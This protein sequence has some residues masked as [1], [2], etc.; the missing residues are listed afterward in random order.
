MSLASFCNHCT[1]RSAALPKDRAGGSGTTF[2]AEWRKAIQVGRAGQ[3]KE[4]LAPV[5]LADGAGGWVTFIRPHSACK[6]QVAAGRWLCCCWR[7]PSPLLSANSCLLPQ[8]VDSS[9]KKHLRESIAGGFDEER[10]GTRI[11]F[12]NLRRQGRVGEVRGPRKPKGSFAHACLLHLASA[13]VLSHAVARCG[14]QW[15]LS[16]VPAPAGSWRRS[17]RG[18]TAMP[19]L[20]PW[21]C[22]RSAHSPV[23]LAGMWVVSGEPWLPH[24]V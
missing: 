16:Y 22:C 23:L 11:G 2:S 1:A 4:M 18:G 17:W 21:R 20:P 24:F 3:C 14:C 15:S 10:F 12:G 7:S 8:E 13:P 19:H 6:Q 9:V 5:Q